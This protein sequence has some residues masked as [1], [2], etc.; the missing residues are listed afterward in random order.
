MTQLTVNNN[1]SAN[2]T[3]IKLEDNA[4]HAYG[5]H[6]NNFF[7]EPVLQ[8]EGPIDIAKIEAAQLKKVEQKIIGLT[9]N[10]MDIRKKF[11]EYQTLQEELEIICLKISSQFDKN[12]CQS[13]QQM[14]DTIPERAFMQNLLRLDKFLK[15]AKK[16]A[17]QQSAIADYLPAAI[18]SVPDNKEAKMLLVERLMEAETYAFAQVILEPLSEK[19][20]ADGMVH[21]QLAAAYFWQGKTE[22]ALEFARKAVGM[23]PKDPEIRN[24]YAKILCHR[25]KYE[26]GAKQGESALKLTSSKQLKAEIHTT[27]GKCYY[28]LAL[29]THGIGNNVLPHKYCNKALEHVTQSQALRKQTKIFGDQI[30]HHYNLG[31]ILV[32]L[33]KYEEAIKALTKGAQLAGNDPSHQI[34][35]AVIKAERGKA[36]LNVHNYKAAITDLLDA[37]QVI[38]HDALAK[39]SI[40]SDIA[41]LLQIAEKQQMEIERLKR[42]T[43]RG[44][45][46]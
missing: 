40:G 6:A 36:Y 27:L 11:A 16:P 9:A 30:D 22:K 41:K 4:A 31:Q 28:G 43:N 19:Y 8:Q 13:L 37:Q 14:V 45:T 12:Y 44:A 23:I 39:Q 25:L 18:N 34:M 15:T 7:N 3:S 10:S 1:S 26:E 42:S 33:G 24:L 46:M 5:L 20:P 38:N 35:R 29:H 32:A 2:V 17:A 21:S